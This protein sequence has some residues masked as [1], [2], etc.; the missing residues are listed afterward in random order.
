VK[1]FFIAPQVCIDFRNGFRITC[2]MGLLFLTLFVTNSAFA[3]AAPSYYLFNVQPPAG[4]PSLSNPSYVYYDHRHGELYVAD[5][6]N[7]R[8][9]I[10]D[11]D[12]DYVF[13]FADHDHLQS[14][15]CLAA[16]STGRILALCERQPD[17]I[18]VL[19]YD[20]RFL[21]EWLVKDAKSDST[22]RASSFTIGRGDTVYVATEEPPRIF[23]YTTDG[24]RLWETDILTDLKPDE[25]MQQALG[26]IAYIAGRLI[27]PT[28]MFS[29]LSVYDIQ[30]QFIK[31]FGYAGGAPGKLSF[32]IAAASDGQGGTL[33]LDKHR[34]TVLEYGPDDMFIQEIGG[35][36]MGPGW[37]YHPISLAADDTGRCY[38]LQSFMGRI[39][40]VK[41]PDEK[42]AT[43]QLISA[44]KPQSDLQAAKEDSK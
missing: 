3:Q 41:V 25:R 6:G 5:T 11:K 14:P 10:F 26:N 42:A 27:V 16:D 21:T 13:E 20:G 37:F 44:A 23:A 18:S 28:P 19:D 9:L 36:G 24:K 32:P 15:R 22:V 43:N 17:R 40:A 4:V 34:H 33:V 2:G 1:K 7:D 31:F 30:G 8:I 38:V 12:G 35:M 29:N 39:Q